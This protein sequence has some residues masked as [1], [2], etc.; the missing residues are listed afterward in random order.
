MNV[1]QAGEEVAHIHHC[2]QNTIT[3]K[4]EREEEDFVCRLFSTTRILDCVQVVAM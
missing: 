1:I 4:G 3:L 2:K